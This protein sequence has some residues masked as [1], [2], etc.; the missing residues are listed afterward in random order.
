MTVTHKILINKETGKISSPVYLIEN[1]RPEPPDC[2]WHDIEK[3]TWLYN[4][5]CCD[6][7]INLS[8]MDINEAYWDFEAE[9]WI[10][11]P[12]ESYPT[13]EK[14]KINRN[15]LL[16]NSDRIFVTLTN[17]AEIDAWKL[18]R[19][20]LR[21]MFVNLPDNFDWNEIIFPR[22]PDDIAELHR[23]ANEGNEEAANIILRDKL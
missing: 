23:L 6:P 3:G 20:Q 1:K 22:T 10:E 7:P 8:H 17:A 9:E 18:Y 13:F 12:T 19:Q 14:T 11:V 4:H 5:F 2:I 21:D 16:K 15:E